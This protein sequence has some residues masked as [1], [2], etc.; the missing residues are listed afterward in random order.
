LSSQTKLADPH[1][2]G[3]PHAGPPCHPR[4][5]SGA[6][7]G[8]FTP[9]LATGGVLGGALGIAWSLGWPGSPSGAFAMVGAAAMIGASLQ[10]SCLYVRAQ[11]D[12]DQR[13]YCDR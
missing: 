11:G 12:R 2:T 13:P 7:G 5:H 1:L 9:T 4:T 10:G 3:K 8:L 6:S